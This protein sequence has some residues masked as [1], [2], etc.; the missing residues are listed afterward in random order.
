MLAKRGITTTHKCQRARGQCIQLPPL[1]HYC[2]AGWLAGRTNGVYIV[3][4]SPLG[5]LWRARGS[6]SSQRLDLGAQADWQ[7]S[8]LARRASAE[9]A[10]WRGAACAISLARSAPTNLRP[11]WAQTLAGNW[12]APVDMS[13]ELGSEG[14]R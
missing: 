9:D 10:S 14:E 3:T 5:G 7:A 8:W 1:I 4:Q 2:W 11:P 13:M 6:K 12:R